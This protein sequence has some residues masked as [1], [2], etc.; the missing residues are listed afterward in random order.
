MSNAPRLP[1]VRLPT[2]I[3]GAG[4]EP[5]L[6]DSLVLELPHS[7][8]FGFAWPTDTG[9]APSLPSLADRHA[10]L[11]S[12]DADSVPSEHEPET[13]A[14]TGFEK[15]KT[16]RWST[17]AGRKGHGEESE[18]SDFT[19]PTNRLNL[20]HNPLDHASPPL[21][22]LSRAFSVPLPSQIGHLKNPKR[23][24][25][26]SSPGS[27]TPTVQS[28]PDTVHFH[29][30]SLEL[31][32]SVQM[33][34]QTLLRLS[35]PQIFDPAKE[36]FSACALPI[37]TPSV[38]ALFTVMKNLNF[39]SANMVALSTPLSSP[40]CDPPHRTDNEGS[41]DP[42]ISNTPFLAPQAQLHDFDI[43]EALQSVG[44][45]LSGM[46]ADVSVELV[47][48]HGNVG[49]KHI[50]VKGDEIGISY[51]LSHIVRQI[52][53]TAH[54]GDSVQIGLYLVAP[55]VGSPESG[56][57]SV[58]EVPLD[59]TE[60]ADT[61]S[62]PNPDLPLRCTFQITHSFV[63]HIVG[64]SQLSMTLERGSPAVVNPAIILSDND[65]ILQAFPDFKLSGEPTLEDLSQFVGTL[66]G[67]KVSLYA[68]A[69]G[70]FAQHLTS[71]LASWGLD[72][73][74]ASSDSD[75]EGSPI[76]EVA[77]P[78]STLPEQDSPQ[79]APLTA[80]AQNQSLSFIL[81]DDDISRAE[82]SQSFQLS[83]KRPNLAANHRPRSS[84]QVTR[85]IGH[86]TPTPSAR[87]APVILH[88]T[89]LANFK[90]VKG[91][92]QSVL[93]PSTGTFIR[94][95]EVIVIPKPA[96]PRRVLTALHTAATKPIVDP[97]FSPIATSPMSPGLYPTASYFPQNSSPKSPMTRPSSSPRGFSYQS[98][99]SPRA[100][101]ELYDTSGLPP[102]PLGLSEGM[103]YFSEAAEK[104]GSSPS[105]G[106]VI[107]SPNG[108][109]AGIFFHPPRSR[110]SRPSSQ[111]VSVE[112]GQVYSRGN[113][114]HSDSA[115]RTRQA[116]GVTFLNLPGPMQ[117]RRRSPPHVPLDSVR[118]GASTPLNAGPDE[119]PGVS[120][121]G[122]IGTSAG[123][124]QV[125][126][127]RASTVEALRK[128]TSPPPPRPSSTSAIVP[129]TR[130]ASGPRR[131][132]FE[133]TSSSPM[134]KGKASEP[135]IVPPIS[136][137][138][139]EDNPINQTLLS[140]FMR[141]KKIKYDV[142]KNGEEAV[143][144]WSSGRFHLILMDIQM[145]VMD[146][147]S[148]TKEIRRLEKLNNSQGYPGTPQTEGQRTP[149]DVSNDSRMSST[150]FRSSVIIVALTASSLQS[151]R[152]A[153]LAAGC[154]DFLTKPVSLDWLNS[155]IIE[156]G[157]I[158][159]LQMFADDRPD[160]IKSV[161]A[162]QTV[163]AQ[164]IAR[165]L[166]MPEGRVSPSPSRPLSQ[167]AVPGTFSTTGPVSSPSGSDDR[168][169]GGRSTTPSVVSRSLCPIQ[170]SSIGT[171]E[172][173]ITPAKAKE[174]S[175][176][177][178]GP[179]EEGVSRRSEDEVHSSELAEQ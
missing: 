24:P 64:A 21:H 166:H 55:V 114:R 112:N 129:S 88:F 161:S 67:K 144:K 137:L 155:K 111:S 22:R 16:R 146:G 65:P 74:H 68:N 59:A 46:A 29:E 85:A 72:V 89:S 119:A 50:A 90:L 9:P 44:D 80:K 48:F 54:F 124:R 141:K 174:V 118:S 132:Q 83:R 106:L 52:L 82:L 26:P 94:L 105:S 145:P 162:G 156:W 87:S 18:E 39:M 1:T 120:P 103:D 178:A 179:S 113:R 142:A 25:L 130:R 14:N 117:Q 40:S 170:E 150:P 121:T 47:L 66:K 93:G 33:V 133:N 45:A 139:V 42:T 32:D 167:P 5:S 19:T 86:S 135:S 61:T 176:D 110:S 164:N 172:W 147:I 143:E 69:S 134:R 15:F 4:S 148:A 75:T 11:S 97:F 70:I 100:S 168:T 159:A 136:V 28:A 128:T 41:C 116:G 76:R 6:Q 56:D 169:P 122:H 30:I 3:A 2:A 151:D 131:S 34:I 99:R 102:S 173:N 123:V 27:T 20:E 98:L 165:R 140:T 77:T 149:S 10:S 13:E 108:Q 79:P 152:V 57:P 84:P 17:G 175:S 58:F 51:T 31:A 78:S 138:I 177:S 73:S 36:Q 43:G 101:V 23:S 92:L 35:P 171:S 63:Q 37:P 62:P 12:S 157:S 38:S 60:P 7:G 104:L 126:K 96:G 153:A 8:K 115:E 53:A 127:R 163:Q 81:I 154:N 160:F 125:A 95:P 158:K 71:Y 109:P 107:Q 91:V 49:M